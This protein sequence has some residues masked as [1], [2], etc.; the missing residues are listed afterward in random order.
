MKYYD[1]GVRIYEERKESRLLFVV[2]VIRR[3][4]L[5]DHDGLLASFDR[6]IAFRSVGWSLVTRLSY[7]VGRRAREEERKRGKEI[8]R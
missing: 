5:L 1:R 6:S 3:S 7:V 4:F 8:G 2:R